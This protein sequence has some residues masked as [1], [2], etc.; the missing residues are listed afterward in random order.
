MSR[1]SKRRAAILPAAICAA[2]AAFASAGSPETPPERSLVAAI[3]LYGTSQITV[4]DI[5]KRFGEPIRL[6][7]RLEDADPD[8][9]NELER[10]IVR[11]IEIMA[12]FAWVELSVVQYFEPRSVY[13]T[14]DVVDADDR[15]TRMPFRDAPTGGPMKDPAGLIEA[16]S[17]FID[18]GF[19]LIRSG[20]I[21]PGRVECPS[22]HCTFDWK[23]PRLAPFVE[24]FVTG[25]PEHRGE[26]TAI[27]ERSP[28][29][30][31]RAQAAFLLAYLPDG[32]EV[33]KFMVPATLDS[34]SWVRNNAMRVLSDI[35][36]H[37]PEIKVPLDPILGALDFPATT[38]RNK[39]SSVLAAL[40]RREEHRDAITRRAGPVLLEMLRLQQPNN[41][42]FAYMILTTI[43]GKQYGE[44]D[45]VRWEAWVEKATRTT[46]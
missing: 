42:D 46:R 16:M 7:V 40:T 24:Q 27:L 17:R 44:R 31:Q 3:D 6:M 21:E 4:A 9:A 41:H 28:D 22:F 12:D 36:W 43:S 1:R 33:V 19:A 45:Y 29:T 23:H 11:A 37:H 26:L 14:V 2:A 32:D 8:R 35:A 34:H 38:D 15:E 18:T 39:A 20:E 30:E 5:E 10:R 25:V 13:V